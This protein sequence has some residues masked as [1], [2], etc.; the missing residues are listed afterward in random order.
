MSPTSSMPVTGRCRMSR[1]AIFRPSRSTA[2]RSATLS[3]CSML[4]LTRI[5]AMPSVLSLVMSPS[6]ASVCCTPSA[7][8]G[9]SMMTTRLPHSTARATATAC[10]WPP[11][12]EPALD[13][14]A[15]ICS[16]RRS[17]ACSTSRRIRRLSIRR[18]AVAIWPGP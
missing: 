17:K 12:S 8:A 5:V 14:T 10:R 15:G 3:T 1:S 2:T 11:D 6:T 7:A 13:V 9:S 16:P 4:W 18:S